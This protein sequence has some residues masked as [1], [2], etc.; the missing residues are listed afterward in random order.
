MRT[1]TAFV[2]A[3]L[4]TPGVARAWDPPVTILEEGDPVLEDVAFRGVDDAVA[5]WLRRAGETEV[6]GSRYRDGQ[7]DSG[8]PLYGGPDSV[9]FARLADDGKGRTFAIYA[10]ESYPLGYQVVTVFAREF[11]GEIWS[12]QTQLGHG[13]AYEEGLILAAGPDGTAMAVFVEPRWFGDL[14]LWA[15]RYDPTLGWTEAESLGTTS[16]F[17]DAAVDE[18]GRA[19][20]AWSRHDE[21]FEGLWAARFIPDRG[22]TP[23]EQ[24]DSR[25]VQ[26]V[27]VAMAEGRALAIWTRSDEFGARIIQNLRDPVTGW[28]SPEA[29]SFNPEIDANWVMGASQE[30]AANPAGDGV[31]VFRLA[32]QSESS[33]WTAEIEGLE[34]GTPRQ[35]VATEVSGISVDVNSEGD[36]ALA[37]LAPSG[38]V[39][40]TRAASQRWCPVHAFEASGDGGSIALGRIRVDE[41]GGVLLTW[42]EYDGNRFVLR[43]SHHDMDPNCVP[44]GPG[45]GESAV[46]AVGVVALSVG[47][48]ITIVLLLRRHRRKSERA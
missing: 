2:M 46:A 17:A 41:T 20:V 1:V 33:M 36:A 48:A 22:W 18:A 19:T 47:A 27:R 25:S 4:L 6:W 28:G 29:L 8:V 23:A 10:V 14:E 21:G 38:L 5:V 39:A 30:V 35:M 15:A 34:V 32:R 45:G 24:V 43:S 16:G 13:S 11:D 44:S 12:P 9:F 37:W 3:L 7:W 40:R 26:S 31:A 42:T